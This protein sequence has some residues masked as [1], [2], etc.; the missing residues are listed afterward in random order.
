MK[1]KHLLYKRNQLILLNHLTI[2]LKFSKTLQVLLNSNR[3][4]TTT[5]IFAN[6]F[7]PIFNQLQQ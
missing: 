6:Y 3:D 4:L 5:S 2:E 7:L 1:M